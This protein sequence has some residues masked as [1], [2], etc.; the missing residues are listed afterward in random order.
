MMAYLGA[1]MTL[2][3][4]AGFILTIGMGVDSNVLIFERIKEEL[5]HRQGASGPRSTP[6]STASGGRSSTRTSSSLIARAAPAAVRHRPDPRLRDDADHRAARRTSS[7]RCSCRA[8]CSSWCCRGARQRADA[9]HLDSYADSSRTPITTSSAGGGTPSSCRWSSSS[10]AP[11]MMCHA[12]TA[13]RHRLLRRHDRRRQFDQAV[14][15]D[16]VRGAVD[17][18][19]GRRRSSSSTATPARRRVADPAA[20]DRGAEQGVESRAGVAADRAGAAEG[21]L[22]KLRGRSARAGRSRHRRRPA[23]ARAS[24]RRWPRS[25]RSRS[26]SPSGSGSRSP[27]APSPRPS[28]TSS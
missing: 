4:I 15:E 23:A 19:A 12:R 22:A 25:S 28:T 11:C 2:P 5:A 1:T 6:A 20:A 8:R 10:P 3:G 9:E 27:S 16:Q 26:T 14:T 13:A 17:A 21:G 7:R 24:T 18:V